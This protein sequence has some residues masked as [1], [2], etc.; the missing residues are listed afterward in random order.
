MS[1]NPGMSQS[2]YRQPEQMQPA[3]ESFDEEAFA[4]AFDQAASAETR[5]LEISQAQDEPI[6]LNESAE[7]FMHS[8]EAHSQERLGADLIHD[9]D[10]NV[11][12]D[13]P[14]Q[15]DPD[16]LSRT[17]ADLLERVKDNTSDKFQNS[18]FLQ[19]MRHIRD[20]EVVVEGDK[21]VDA[22]GRDIQPAQS[23]AVAP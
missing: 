1:M 5:D 13:A 19:L 16:A 22:Q 3:A 15:A 11:D 6:L 12:Q 23:L 8:N 14:S 20:K 9:P 4:R 21:I 17:A 18:Q 7:A 10:G 2:Q